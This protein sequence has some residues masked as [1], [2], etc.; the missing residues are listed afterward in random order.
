MVDPK[1]NDG[2]DFF[3][4]LNELFDD[5]LD[6]N[7]ELSADAP[8][9]ADDDVVSPKPTVGAEATHDTTAAAGEDEVLLDESWSEL[10]LAVEPD[11][12]A[13]PNPEEATDRDA[14]SPVDE[15]RQ[16]VSFDLQNSNESGLLKTVP[17][18]PDDSESAA[19]EYVDEFDVAR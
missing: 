6:K 3:D 9:D 18:M 5:A 14:G 16:D 2:D 15:H 19:A 8:R 12:K 13:I 10:E 11:L 4:E 1:S 17:L 7:T